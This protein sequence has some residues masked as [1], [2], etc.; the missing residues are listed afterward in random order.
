MLMHFNPSLPATRF[1]QLI[2][3][4]IPTGLTEAQ[5]NTLN[6]FNQA[7]QN[8]S[9]SGF[10]QEAEASGYDIT[11]QYSLSE[12]TFEF[13][14]QLT[15]RPGTPWTDFRTGA[16]ELKRVKADSLQQSGWSASTS[17]NSLIFS[18]RRNLYDIKM[19]DA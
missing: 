6:Q 8:P 5:S 10:V 14:A 17:V 1:G 2:P 12:D 4:A 16:T 19:A 3:I 7:W 15:A 9:L 18:L 11:P 13:S